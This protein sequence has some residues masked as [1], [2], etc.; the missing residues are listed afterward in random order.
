MPPEVNKNNTA[1]AI[2]FIVCGIVIFPPLAVYLATKFLGEV[3]MSDSSSIKALFLMISFPI[4][5]ILCVGLVSNGV[6]I[7]FAT[8]RV[9]KPNA[10]TPSNFFI[11]LV[12]FFTLLPFSMFIAYLMMPIIQGL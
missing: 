5:Y 6:N 4:S 9:Q 2:S 3:F 11:T 1:K 8:R 10:Y 12:I 7:L